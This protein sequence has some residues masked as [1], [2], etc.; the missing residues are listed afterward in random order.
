M[1]KYRIEVKLL[2]E[3]IFGSGHS[4]PSSVDLEVVHDEYG[5]PFMKAKT[6]KGNFRDAMSDIVNFLGNEKYE[7]LE[8]RL[9]G[10]END[11]TNSWKTLKFSDCML[12]EN[13]RNILTYGVNEGTINPLEV[14]EALTEVRNFTSVEDDGSYKEGSLRE[15]RVV[16]KG[17]AFYVK[18]YCDRGLLEDE[19]GL[20]AITSKYLRHIGTMK[21][22]GKGEVECSFHV[23]E[24]GEYKDRTD[25][26]MNKF[27]KG[28]KLNG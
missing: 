23:L 19:L 25:Y 11:G 3:T 10:Q 13:I 4:I 1:D 27:L 12:N 21:T 28:V 6:F 9:L 17:L 20:L 24:N 18:L 2:T 8:E 5:L 16:K 26:Y 7:C 22:R 14:K 15:M